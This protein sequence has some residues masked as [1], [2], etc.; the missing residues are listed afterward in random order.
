MKRI[1]YVLL[2]ML[3]IM[4]SAQTESITEE[5]RDSIIQAFKDVAKKAGGGKYEIVYGQEQYYWGVASFKNG[6]NFLPDSDNVKLKN[7]MQFAK[8]RFAPLYNMFY[9]SVAKSYNMYVR[10][11][12]FAEVDT[13]R[14]ALGIMPKAMMDN[15][16]LETSFREFFLFDYMK[17][18]T[19]SPFVHTI[20]AEYRRREQDDIYLNYVSID[21]IVEQKELLAKFLKSLNGYEQKTFKVKYEYDNYKMKE[22]APFIDV[23]YD[24]LRNI[25][26]VGTHYV[27]AMPKVVIQEKCSNI[28]SLLS[29]VAKKNKRSR[30]STYIAPT[31]NFVNDEQC[32]DMAKMV[33]FVYDENIDKQDNVKYFYK[34]ILG[35]DEKG[36]HIL[37][38]ECN[39]MAN[40]IPM[41]W[42][43]IKTLYNDKVKWEKGLEP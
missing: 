25:K 27:I 43:N 39:N 17:S 41:M 26:I 31:Y 29:D 16:N 7:D 21:E 22:G 23:H 18:D 14:F 4:A 40:P 24:T 30:F 42:M 15:N 3:P 32:D 38:A 28:I 1:I 5:I 35:F 20:K 10:S 13:L 6:L 33:T 34:I 37:E 12:D 9:D 11:K 36:L 2:M 19:K 8:K